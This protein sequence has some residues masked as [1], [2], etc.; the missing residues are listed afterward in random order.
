MTPSR[1]GASIPI[2]S[3]VHPFG[4]ALILT[5]A[6]TFRQPSGCALWHDGTLMLLTPPM[7]DALRH[8][9]PRP[10][11]PPPPAFDGTLGELFRDYI[12]PNLP[13][14]AAVAAIHR[15]LVRYCAQN[16][17]LLLLRYMSGETRGETVRTPAGRYRPTDNSPAW[18]MHFLAVNGVTLPN[19]EHLEPLIAEWPCHMFE[20]ARLRIRT[21]SHHGWHIAHLLP[22]KDRNTSPSTWGPFDL[23][24]RFIRNVH[25]CNYSYLPKPEW[26]RFGADATVIAFLAQQYRERY[27]GRLARVRR[28]GRRR[29]GSYGD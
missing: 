3:R 9:T 21:V 2:R 13:P 24:R 15:T 29:H 8:V 14:K 27:L 7:V 12:A 26:P 28:A 4:I 17:P 22:V 6:V 5:V 10:Q 25:P 20:V 11:V 19:A 1:D 23:V 18:L 16:D